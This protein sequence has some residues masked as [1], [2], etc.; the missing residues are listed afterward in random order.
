MC[1]THI[2]IQLL[3]YCKI[4]R[5]SKVVKPTKLLGK[6]FCELYIVY[7]KDFRKYHLPPPLNEHEIPDFL[8]GYFLI[9]ETSLQD[10]NFYRTVVFILSHDSGGAIGLV[11]NRPSNTTLAELSEGLEET[12]FSDYPVYIGGPVDRNYLFALHS[13]LP[14]GSKSDGAIEAAEGV[15][16]EPDFELLYDYFLGLKEGDQDEQAPHI[17]FYAGYAGWSQGQLEEEL[18]RQDW[19][20]LPGSSRL[21]FSPDPETAWREA[22]FKKGGIYWV[23]AET[24]SSPSLN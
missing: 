2:Y 13:G 6:E 22:L 9:S 10:P 16:F 15:V 8:S 14:D 23:A 18:S 21:V 4:L 17:R 5:V 20:V 3:I 1:Y 12:P 7:M 24:G 11:I 19:I